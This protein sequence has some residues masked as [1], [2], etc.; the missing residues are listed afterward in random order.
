[1][2]VFVDTNVVMEMLD[3]RN[4]A[5]LIGSIF[6]WL[7]NHDIKPYL[8]VGSFYTITYLS[9][10]LLHKQ[11]LTRPQLTGKLRELLIGIIDEFQIS[12]IGSKELLKGVSDEQFT[13]LEDSYQLQSASYADCDILI[14][15]NTK[16]FK[17]CTDS[18]IKIYSPRLFFKE[19]IEE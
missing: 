19:F 6:D 2:K 18:Q 10:R 7:D 16:H 11:G 15:I 13:D 8:S 14:T 1:M 9:E 3:S 17:D 12:S 5:D 4:E